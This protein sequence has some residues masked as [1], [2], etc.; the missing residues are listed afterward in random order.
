MATSSGQQR[1]RPWRYLTAFLGIVVV[2]YALVLFTGGG[3]LAPKLGIDL[4]GGTRV[5][6][7]ARTTDG[8]PPPRDQL[9]QAQEIIEQRVNGLGVSGAEVQLDGS[10]IVITVPGDEGEQARSL[11]QTAQLRFREVVQQVPASATPQPPGG[12]APGAP[13][14]AGQQPGQAPAQ[15]PAP[16]PAGE[17]APPAGQPAPQPQG[18]GDPAAQERTVAPVAHTAPLQD[19]PPA[20][21][22]P[23]GGGAAPTDPRVAAEV[24]QLRATRQSDDQAVQLQA[25]LALDCN[26]PDPLQGYDDPARPLVTCGDGGAN[27]YVLGPSFIEGT[28]IA[29]AQAQQAQNGAGWVVSLTFKQPA[30]DQWGQYTTA[31]VGKQTAFVLDGDVV[32]AP[33]VNGPIFGPTEVS[34]QFNQERAQDLA[35]TLRYGSL[36]LAFDSGTAQT[37]S[38][39]LGLASLEAGLIAGAVGLALVFLYCLFY[40]RL[41]GLLTILSLA[42]SGIVVYAVLILL[43]RWIGFT[44][45]LAGVAGFIIAIGITADS[46]VIFFERLKDEMRDGRTFRSAVPRSWERARRTI[47]TADAVSFLAAAV[48]Y[49]LAVGEVRGFAFTLGMSTV[50]DLVVVFLVT[51]PLVVLISRSRT[52]GR[53]GLSGLAAVDRIGARHRRDKPVVGRR[54]TTSTSKGAGA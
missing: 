10:N 9:V 17:P 6:L 50:L 47:L 12:T 51:F 25:V 21:A 37:V 44:L 41:L 3:N 54:A 40:Y 7:T 29:S 32:S 31:N 14:A 19:P 42:L 34:G 43:G 27:K 33:R 20:P 35:Q 48:L 13:P 15:Q 23:P 46:F 53:P 49:I 52:L 1:V 26:A 5:T 39:S 16:A 11:G 28:E 24:E 4:Q 38:A 22:P 45:D 36:P 2:L 30:A 18:M 8:E